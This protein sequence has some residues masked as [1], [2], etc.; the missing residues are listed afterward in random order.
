MRKNVLPITAG[1]FG[2]LA[3]A[4]MGSL[5]VA[6]T[7]S[8]DLVDVT[9]EVSPTPHPDGDLW[10]TWV[11]V[12]HFDNLMDQIALVGSS[13]AQ[14]LFFITGGG[15]IYNQGLFGGQTLN[16]FP[17]L[18]IGGE[19]WDSYVTIGATGFPSGVQF[20]P[21]FLGDFGG[22]P[23]DVQVILGSSFG[24]EANGAW[25]FFGDS[26]LVGEWGGNVIVAQFTVPKG[27]GFR[28]E[29]NLGWLPA[30]PLGGDIELTAFVVDN[31]PAPGALALL[32]L[33]GLAGA[34]RRRRRG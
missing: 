23:P 22:D 5:L 20:T 29:G 12:A 34:R 26:P 14:Q 32:G 4:A 9:I 24:P 19:A 7:A 10:D 28:L 17:S 18:G 8:A 31:I 3:L 13:E 2:S 11:V 30:S 6:G 16:D 15:D 25:F 33:A 21:D 1:V 27:V